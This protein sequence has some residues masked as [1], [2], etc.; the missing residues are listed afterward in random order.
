MRQ[1]AIIRNLAISGEAAGRLS[2][3]F[4]MRHKGFLGSPGQA[5]LESTCVIQVHG[6]MTWAGSQH[7]KSAWLLTDLIQV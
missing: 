5:G 6:Y 4:G 2:E 7:A 3:C 1:D